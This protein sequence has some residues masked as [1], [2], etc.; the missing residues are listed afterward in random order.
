MRKRKLL[1]HS[2]IKENESNR[3]R[4]VNYEK[5]ISCISSGGK[6]GDEYINVANQLLWSQYPDLQGLCTPVLVQKF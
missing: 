1:S 6:L 5:L 4:V 3:S 2:D